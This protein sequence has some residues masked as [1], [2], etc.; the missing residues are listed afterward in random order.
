MATHAVDPAYSV[1]ILSVLQNSMALAASRP[2]VELSQHCKGEADSKASAIE[3]R[4]RL[5]RAACQSTSP[6][7]LVWR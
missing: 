7:R 3:T 6:T 2:R 5:Q 4:L 1:D